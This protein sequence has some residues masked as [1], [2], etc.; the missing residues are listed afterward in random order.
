MVREQSK[1]RLM[2]SDPGPNSSLDQGEQEE[3]GG[4]KGGDTHGGDQWALGPH[5]AFSVL[6]LVSESGTSN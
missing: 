4:G 5:A 2:V 3:R 6:T 1:H